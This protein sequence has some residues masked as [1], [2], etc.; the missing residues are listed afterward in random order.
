MLT[1][2]GQKDLG[3]VQDIKGLRFASMNGQKPPALDI[4]ELWRQKVSKLL[5]LIK[6]TAVTT[7]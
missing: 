6:S 4:P 5:V 3:V 7:Q 1:D 2:P